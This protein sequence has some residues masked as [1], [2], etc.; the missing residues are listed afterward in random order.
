MRYLEYREEGWPIGSG[1]I[2]SG[3]KQFQARFKGPGMRWTRQGAKRML[4]LRSSIMSDYF[5]FHWDTLANSP[6][7]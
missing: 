2:E 6:P 7:I 4:V 3:C 5:D 1:S